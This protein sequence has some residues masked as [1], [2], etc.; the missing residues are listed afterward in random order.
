MSHGCKCSA[1]L[2]SSLL[3]PFLL[4]LQ[5]TLIHLFSQAVF[6]LLCQPGQVKLS[7]SFP[8]VLQRLK[9]STSFPPPLVSVWLLLFGA[10]LT[11]SAEHH[12]KRMCRR[13]NVASFCCLIQNT[14]L[15]VR[16]LLSGFGALGR[17]WGIL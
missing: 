16:R 15:S 5:S 12:N 4:I 11:S 1:L 10:I 14:V 3:V 13:R 8:A 17:L 9:S 2:A 7:F 6:R